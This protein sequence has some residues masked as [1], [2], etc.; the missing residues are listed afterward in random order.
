[1]ERVLITGAAGF[2]ARHLVR[3]LLDTGTAERI[4]GVDVDGPPDFLRNDDV[5]C[6]FRRMDLMDREAVGALIRKERPDWIVHLASLSSVA[7]SWEKPAA[8][9]SNNTGIFLNIADGARQLGKGCRILSV[10]SSEVYGRVEPGDLPIGEGCRVRATSPYGVARISQEMLSRVYWEG[11]GLDVV[12]TR[13]F[14][15]FGPFQKETFVIADFS[16]QFALAERSGSRDFELVAGDTDVVRDFTDV[17]EVV[18]AY[19]L[20]LERGRSGETYNVCSGV[21]TGLGTVID[22]LGRITGLRPAV[23]RSVARIRPVENPAIIGDA[24]KI[25]ADC[26]WTACVK[27]EV[28]L[29]D[30]MNHWRS[31]LAAEGTS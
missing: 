29:E 9:F 6:A 22:L 5:R 28:A 7:S 16:R 2:V 3:H 31:V 26:G 19:T 18:R 17:R 23:T 24:S 25:S 4:V 20:L 10:G 15:H 11:Y 21:G 8:S 27:F 12:M 14:N 1:M 13:S 30:T